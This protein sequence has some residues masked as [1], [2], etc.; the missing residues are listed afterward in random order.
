MV[1]TGLSD[2]AY[3][4][5]SVEPSEISRQAL[6][7]STPDSIALCTAF[8]CSEQQTQENLFKLTFNSLIPIFWNNNRN[9]QILGLSS[10]PVI[11]L[12]VHEASRAR[13]PAASEAANSQCFLVNAMWISDSALHCALEPRE[14]ASYFK[15]GL[16]QGNFRSGFISSLKINCICIQRPS[17]P[18]SV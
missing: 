17:L 3:P 11:S 4:L 6:P 5:I 10:F 13:F 16:Y 15:I 2:F 1:S 7:Q 8:F 12:Q 18:C 14:S 9:W